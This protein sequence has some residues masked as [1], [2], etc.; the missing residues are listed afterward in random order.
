MPTGAKIIDLFE[1]LKDALAKGSPRAPVAESVCTC[2][3]DSPYPLP[4]PVC[5]PERTTD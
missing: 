3:A 1:A 5:E 4:C 2:D